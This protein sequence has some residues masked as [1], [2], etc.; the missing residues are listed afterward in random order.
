MIG[1]ISGQFPKKAIKE[2]VYV[3][4]SPIPPLEIGSKIYSHTKRVF[5]HSKKFG[6][7]SFSNMRI[8]L[9][10]VNCCWK[11]EK[12]EKTQNK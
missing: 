5:G 6:P 7:K 2:M 12:D 11:L 1:P 10:E 8:K 9:E 4:M 3:K